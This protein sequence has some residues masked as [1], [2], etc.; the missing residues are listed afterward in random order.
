MTVLEGD[1]QMHTATDPA[2]ITRMELNFTRDMPGF[3]GARHFVL[4]PVGEESERVFARLRCTDTVYVQGSKALNDLTL[5]VM[6]PG[7]LWHDYEV[8]IEEAMVEDLG[9][10]SPDDVVLL[11]I[12]HPR[13]PLSSST[14]NL[15]SPIVVN[16]RTGL[17]DQLVPSLSELEVGW[18]VRT[19]FP[20]E[21]ED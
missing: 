1:S 13:E 15:Y 3:S 20:T 18:S 6:S 9:L 8:H 10:T 11:A 4:E 2:L 12:V 14:A 16:R 7:F 21:G 19:P 17:A 5:L